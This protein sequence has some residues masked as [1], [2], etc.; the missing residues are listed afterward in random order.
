MILSA[1]FPMVPAINTAA[2]LRLTFLFANSRIN[3]AIPKILILMMMK[4]G[5]GNDREIPLFSAG[6]MSVVPS[7]YLRL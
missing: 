7:R 6:R 2:I 5:T 3:A 4:N 1:K